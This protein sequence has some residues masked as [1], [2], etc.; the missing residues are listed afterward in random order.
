MRLT[1]DIIDAI[2]VPARGRVDIPED[3]PGLYLRVTANGAK[4]WTVR[5]RLKGSR[6]MQRETLGKYADIAP[7]K[8]RQMAKKVMGQV[9][10]G[11]APNVARR[12]AK[13]EEI[14][15]SLHRLDLLAERY[16]ADCELGLHRSN[17][18]PKK[19]SVIKSERAIWED[20]IKPR[21]GYSPISSIARSEIIDFVGKMTRQSASAGRK[22][23]A[24]ISQLFAYAMMKGL[25]DA[26][27]AQM[28][29]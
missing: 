28:A 29:R 21:F 25:V 17:S 3:A 27:L 2:S 6:K 18:R 12:E 14:R 11:N 24:L 23:K 10:E 1:A 8:A 22:A 20:R 7:S 5:Y 15:R 4:S 13:A 16:F 19:G 9:V 26:N